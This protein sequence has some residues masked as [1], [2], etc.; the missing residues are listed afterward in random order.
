M[1]LHPYI[2]NLFA[3]RLLIAL[4]ITIITTGYATA[5]QTNVG[6]PNEQER[7]LELYKE[8]NAKREVT[9]GYRIQI[10][11]TDVREDAYKAKAAI[12]KQFTELPAY[13]DYDQPYYKLRVG[14]YTSR[15]EATSV[16]QQII[17]I[18]PG[19]FIVKDRI[20]LK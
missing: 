1:C 18:Y 3:I 14:D 9:D 16:L 2:K 11:Y 13:V 12:Y 7:L 17:T 5:Q 8:Y 6:T 19:A 15:L 20:K 4:C 10:T